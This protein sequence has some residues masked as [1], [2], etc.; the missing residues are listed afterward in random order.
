MQIQDALGSIIPEEL[1]RAVDET[2][3]DIQK[4]YARR[5]WKTAGIDSGHF[6]EAVRRIL[7][8][9]LFGAYRPIGKSLQSFNEKLLAKYASASGD[10]GLRLLIPRQL[11]ALYALRNK[12]SI[13]HLGIEPAREL[14]ATIL[15]YGAKWVLGE[16]IRLTTDLQ[17]AQAEAVLDRVISQQIIAVWREGD[18]VRVLNPRANAREKV[19]LI[20]SFVGDYDRSDLQKVVEYKNPSDF[21]KV[22]R[23]LHSEG[24]VHFSDPKCQITPLGIEDAR[25]I[26]ERY[27]GEI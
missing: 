2:F 13:G 3:V 26:N 22:L 4:H 14:D 12:R 21:K 8:H 20:L 6:T 24:L 5:E 9:L 18:V 17:P 1:R 16:L 11:W 27:G 25:K 15:L 10:E 23:K 7:D 19:L